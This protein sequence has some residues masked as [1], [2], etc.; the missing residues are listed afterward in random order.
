MPRAGRGGTLVAICPVIARR[1][2]PMPSSPLE[3]SRLSLANAASNRAGA[4]RA[5]L[6]G[7]VP[8]NHP[9]HPKTWSE[10]RQAQ[11]ADADELVRATGI[12]LALAK[13]AQRIDTSW[14]KQP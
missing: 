7:Y 6:G 1:V 13:D 10:E 5:A 3:P 12:E 11:L 2:G 9:A 4:A 8:L 14:P